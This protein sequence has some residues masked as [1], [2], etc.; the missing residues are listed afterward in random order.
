LAHWRKD[1]NKKKSGNSASLQIWK[2]FA[3][4]PTLV[5]GC[6]NLPILW[7]ALQEQNLAGIENKMNTILINPRNQWNSCEKVNS[8]ASV[9]SWQ[10]SYFWWGW[11]P[12]NKYQFLSK[13]ETSADCN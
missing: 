9:S 12:T 13:L 5:A 1:R 8:N 6:R 7:V 11:G 3:D 2:I 10:Q 4:R